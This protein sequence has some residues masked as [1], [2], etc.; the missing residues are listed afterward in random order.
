VY[1]KVTGTWTKV[2]SISAPSSKVATTQFGGNSV[3]IS[4][5]GKYMLVVDGYD[6]TYGAVNKV[7]SYAK[8]SSGN[9]F[10]QGTF[11]NTPA[12]VG[13]GRL[14]QDGSI[15]VLSSG[16]WYTFVGYIFDK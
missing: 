7:H 11:S 8:D 10:Y 6:Y 12:S 15:G 16:S 14:N 3:S 2:Q 5:D 4:T 1:R 9:W 13:Q